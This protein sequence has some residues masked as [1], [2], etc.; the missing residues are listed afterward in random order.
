MIFCAALFL[1]MPCTMASSEVLNDTVKVKMDTTNVLRGLDM[2]TVPDI[3]TLYKVSKKYMGRWAMFFIAIKIEE[4]GNNGKYSWLST[5]HYNLI[6]MRFPKSRRT[7]AI[8]ST[9]TNY[10]IYR[11][12]FD[13]ILDFKI[14]L[15]NIEKKRLEE[16]GKPF[17][18]ELELLDYMTT[19][20]NHFDKWESDMKII[21]KY[22]KKKY[23]T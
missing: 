22:V 17:K 18:D 13:C 2:Q 15:D 9:N 1:A 4:S 12:W 7:Y 8:G 19:R 20:F 10:A 5:T 23:G 6:G 3:A 16:G 11:N 14:Y 21:L